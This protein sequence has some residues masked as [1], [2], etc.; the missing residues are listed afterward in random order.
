MAGR[1]VFIRK[2]ALLSAW[3]PVAVLA[4]CIA[5]ILLGNRSTIYQN[6][7]MP[8]VDHIQ[9]A[10]LHLKKLSATITALNSTGVTGAQR[11]RLTTALQNEDRQIASVMDHFT[12]EWTLAATPDYTATLTGMGKTSLLTDGDRA[13]ETYHTAYAQYAVQ[14]DVLLAGKTSDTQALSAALTQMD[15]SLAKL[16]EVNLAFE[17]MPD[18]WTQVLINQTRLQLIA[19]VAIASLLGIGFMLLL[20]S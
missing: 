7:P 16:V 6:A 2:F 14:R 4:V 5:G 13:I 12:D 18:T 8:P 11:S 15:A 17:N 10:S 19:A 20:I 3:I 1:I 9:E